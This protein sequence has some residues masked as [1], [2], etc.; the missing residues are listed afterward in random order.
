MPLCDCGY[1]YYYNTTTLDCSLCDSFMTCTE[2][3]P[4]QTLCSGFIAG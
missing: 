3:E 4:G 1:S 2:G